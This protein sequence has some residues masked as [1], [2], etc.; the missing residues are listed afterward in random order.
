MYRKRMWMGIS[1]LIACLAVACG[2][3]DDNVKTQ[4]SDNNTTPNNT[5]SNN[6]TP[7]NTTSNNTTPNNTTPNN[8]TPNNMDCDGVANPCDT[9]GTTCDG[10][11]LVTCAANAQ[12]C[13]VETTQDCTANGGACD[14]SGATAMCT[15]GGNP[16]CEPAVQTIS[17]DDEGMTI[18]GD[19]ANGSQVISEHGCAFFGDD[20]PGNESIYIFESSET[21]DVT[22]TATFD[23]AAGDFDLLALEGSDVC[24]STELACL[25]AGASTTSPETLEFGATAGSTTYVVFD[26]FNDDMATTSFT[27]DIACDTP[28]CGDGE[29]GAGEECD[30]MNTDAGDGCD[31]SCQIEPDTVCDGEPSVCTPDICGDGI[32]SLNEQ[33]DDGNTS[34]GDG[35]DA[36]CE[37]EFGFSCDD[38][39]PSSCSALTK[40]GTFAAGEAIPDTS[41]G[42]ISAGG[43]DSYLIEF[44]ETVVLDGT[45]VVGNT[46]D[47]DVTFADTDGN[48]VFASGSGGDED[49]SGAILGAGEYQIDLRAF[50]MDD[51]D[52]Y[53]LS[54]STTAPRDEGSYDAAAAITDITGGPLARGESDVFA[55]TFNNDVMLSGSLTSNGGDADLY[56]SSS[57]GDFLTLV[58]DDGPEPDIP[59]ALFAGTYIFRVN[60]WDGAMDDITDYTLQL[61]T[62]A[63][64]VTDL[65]TFGAGDPIADVT[66]GPLTARAYDH[67]TITFSEAVSLSG[68]L[69][70]NTSG[71]L[72]LLIYDANDLVVDA[73]GSGD[74]VFMDAD[75]PAGTYIVQIVTFSPTA[76]GGDVDAYT[77]TLSSN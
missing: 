37:V 12:G 72:A 15:M 21:V 6:T 53:I 62:M 25:G 47:I 11:S 30:D 35:C 20:Y 77:L 19:T 13:L 45:A 69:G 56:I 54:M 17:C 26:V 63:L 7:N 29:I 28:V 4:N 42:P 22:I 10:D 59:V 61:S 49:W 39:E 43:A 76:M 24:T 14:D 60:A 66:G 23:E 46:G 67:Y 36:M 70:G 51:V 74:D 40:I 75:V 58:A 34:G 44:T 27:L 55:I 33:C 3:G 65:G 32:L 73:F 57:D 9:A 18:S 38:A 50:G 8:T 71:E 1:A 68:T 5:T 16:S 64:N 2:P 31:A 52:G 48:T 41:G